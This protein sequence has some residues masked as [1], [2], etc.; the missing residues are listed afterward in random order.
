[1]TKTL[2][3]RFWSKVETRGPVVRPPLGPCWTW[4]GGGSRYGTLSVKNRTVNAHR[5]SWE[6]AHGAV[7]PGLLVLHRCDNPRCVRPA[8]LFLGSQA[9]NIADRDAK[10]RN[11]T[12]QRSPRAKLTE[13]EARE[14]LAS[15]ETST[16]LARKLGV[17][18]STVKAVRS[19][20][21]WK[22]LRGAA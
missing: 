2:N 9:E 14:I 8:H 17:S 12:G 11:L 13:A 4:T 3:D 1:M 22:H 16:Q 18:C 19:G 20:Q 6:L 7:P 10:G 5:L 21:N 15:E